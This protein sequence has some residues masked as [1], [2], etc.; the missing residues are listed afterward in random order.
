[1]DLNPISG[2]GPWGPPHLGVGRI[3]NPG[4]LEPL[5]PLAGHRPAEISN[6]SQM[7]PNTQV[8]HVKHIKERERYI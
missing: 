5:K 2:S 8:I 1:M 3:L 7:I 6:I 4:I